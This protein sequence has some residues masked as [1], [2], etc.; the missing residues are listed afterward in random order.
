MPH[1]VGGEHRLGR[2]DVHSD[3]RPDIHQMAV[4]Q[5][6]F[7]E[8]LDHRLATSSIRRDGDRWTMAANSSPPMRARLSAGPMMLRR[9]RATARNRPST[10]LWPR[11]SLT[12]ARTGDGEGKGGSVSVNQEG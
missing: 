6:G 12:H 11:L 1:A 10:T 7:V 3:R 5:V 4:D 9:R 2:V 8:R